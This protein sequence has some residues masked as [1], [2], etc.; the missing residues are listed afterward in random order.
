MGPKIEAARRFVAAGGAR[1]VITDLDHLDQAWQGGAGTE[2][3]PDE[4][5]E[6]GR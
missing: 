6:G 5:L 4:A 3:L 1:A 2:I